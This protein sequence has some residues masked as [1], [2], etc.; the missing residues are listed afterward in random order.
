MLRRWDPWRELLNMRDEL[1][2]IFERFFVPSEIES[3]EL[4]WSPSVEMYET[5][6]EL[7]VKAELPG[8]SSKDVDITLTDDALTIKGEKK[9]SEEVKGENYYRKETRYGSFHRTIPIPLPIKK[10]D[11]KA[12]FK[13]GVLEI[14]LPK[15]K[16]STKGIKIKIEEK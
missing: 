1:D 9:E 3:R 4:T 15:A 11:V 12:S 2:R 7:V 5:D 13:D 8:L 14:R 6:N 16:E 10:E